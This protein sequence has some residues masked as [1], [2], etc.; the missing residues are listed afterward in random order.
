MYLHLEKYSFTAVYPS[1]GKYY[2]TNDNGAATYMRF[3]RKTNWQPPFEI[4]FSILIVNL[5]W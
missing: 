5:K 2:L 4:G 3:K 1:F